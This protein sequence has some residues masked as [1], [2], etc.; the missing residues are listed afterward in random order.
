MRDIHCYYTQNAIKSLLPSPKCETPA[1]H[2]R[3]PRPPTLTTETI[4]LWPHNFFGRRLRMSSPRSPSKTHH[5]RPVNLKEL[6]S[7]KVGCG[8]MTLGS[9][10]I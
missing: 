10:Q 2:N 6:S 1:V 8:I 5:I 4:P 9:T 7:K 3:Q